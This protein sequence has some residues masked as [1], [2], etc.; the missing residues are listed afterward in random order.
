[1]YAALFKIGL[2]STMRSPEHTHAL[3]DAVGEEGGKRLWDG[4]GIVPDVMLGLLAIPVTA[5]HR[6]LTCYLAIHYKLSSCEYS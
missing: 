2:T 5:Q 6:V 4:Y 3:M 1:M